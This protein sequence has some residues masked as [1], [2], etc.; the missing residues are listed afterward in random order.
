MENTKKFPENF[1]WGGAVAANQCEG[2]WNQGGRGASISD[3]VTAGAHKKPRK[4]TIN[5]EDDIYYPS[6]NAIKFYE[7]YK[8]DIAMFA[9]MGFKTFR[10]SI[11]WPRIFP[12][13][14]DAEPNEEGLA[15]YDS[16]F[17][18]CL[19]YG[20]EPLVTLHHFEPPMNLAKKYRGFTD[21][22]VIGFFENYVR[23]VF[24]RYKD[25]VKYWLT[26]NELNFGT[27]PHGNQNVLGILDKKDDMYY[28]V[29]HDNTQERFQ[30]LHHA[31][32][33]SA[34]AVKIGHE[35]NPNFQIGCMLAHITM[36]P[37]TCNPIDVMACMEQDNL[38]NNF[39]GDVQ[40]LGEYPYYIEDYFRKNNVT[41]NMEDGDV[42]L[43]KEGKVDFY[44]FSY[45][46]STCISGAKDGDK[47]EG[48]LFG[49]VVNPYLESSEWGWQ[50]DA[51]GLRY[52]LH[53][54]YA[55]YHVPLMI[56]E[57]GLGAV[58]ELVNDTVEDDY[59]IDYLRKHVSEMQLAIEEG[60]DLMGYTMWGCIDLVSAGTGEMKKR[61]GFI[62]VDLDDEGQGTFKRY[63]KKSFNWYKKVIASQG[64]DLV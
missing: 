28:S 42:A 59:R 55:R 11:S 50:V 30:A 61:Y 36:Y 51:V 29:P 33:A 24:T 64:S 46:M 15:F 23:T 18:E 21:R 25:K 49:G 10:L 48:N 4:I 62:Y 14:D 8:E 43:L 3:Y 31:F 22:R 19:K 52:T 45:Y 40:V 16:V 58:D 63:K 41:I 13:G 35:I 6:H 5:I 17:D 7:N 2:G 38:L 60:V 57:N 39:V 26:I 47:A 12:N 53:K 9:E 37:A 32:L 56:V 27:M 54:L 34:S 44:S 1:L 20:I